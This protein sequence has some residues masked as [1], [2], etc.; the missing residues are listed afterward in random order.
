MMS[1][2][3]LQE[4]LKNAEEKHGKDSF[5]AKMLKEQI[6]RDQRGQTAEELYL[7]GSVAR[8]KADPNKDDEKR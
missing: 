6:A 8:P 2:S 5:V 3:M 1:I 4:L 7:T